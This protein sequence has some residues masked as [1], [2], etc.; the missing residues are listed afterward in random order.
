MLRGSLSWHHLVSS[1]TFSS[2]PTAWK[3][4]E[5]RGCLD[6]ALL[7][8]QPR[9]ASLQS[10]ANFLVLLNLCLSTVVSW[11][12]RFSGKGVHRREHWRLDHSLQV[13]RMA[14]EIAGIGRWKGKHSLVPVTGKGERFDKPTRAVADGTKSILCEYCNCY[15]MESLIPLDS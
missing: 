12:R 8:W 13:Q 6:E 15:L 3:D 1:T 4:F 10:L 14:Y 11:F 5:I 7:L 2:L 9:A